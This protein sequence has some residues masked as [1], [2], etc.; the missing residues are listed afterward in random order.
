MASKHW[1]WI[2]LTNAVLFIDLKKAFHTT[3]HDTLLAKLEL[4]GLRGTS[5]NHF[6]NYLSDRT[7]VSVLDNVQSEIN[8]IRC[9]VPRGSILGPLLFL[10]YVKDLRNCNLL[11]D[12]RMYADD[13]NL[14]YASKDREKL[15]SSLTRDLGNLKQWFDSNLNVGY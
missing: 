1:Q 15:F 3:D 11:S 6:R 5:L 12:V 9:A 13:T 10:L 14:T 8:Y 2:Y 4:Y 7:Q